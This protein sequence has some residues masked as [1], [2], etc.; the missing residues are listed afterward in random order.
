MWNLFDPIVKDLKNST[1]AN[2]IWL[3]KNAISAD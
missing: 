2:G 3:Q 1:L